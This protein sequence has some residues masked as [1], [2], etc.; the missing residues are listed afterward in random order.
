VERNNLN[1]KGKWHTSY[2]FS[3][4]EAAKTWG[5]TPAQWDGETDNSRA[6]MLGLEI[7]ISE[8]KAYEDFLEDEKQLRRDAMKSLK[9]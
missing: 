3:E 8:M 7:V 5:L 4:L 2:R 9:G 6:E 1:K